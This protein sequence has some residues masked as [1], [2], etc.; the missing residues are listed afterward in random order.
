M[1]TE[2]DPGVLRNPRMDVYTG[3]EAAVSY[4]GYWDAETQY[5]QGDVVYG[6]IG[7]YP[8]LWL[9]VADSTGVEPFGSADLSE[10]RGYP[11]FGGHVTYQFDGVNFTDL[12]RVFRLTEPGTVE[13]KTE[14]SAVD[15]TFY[16]TFLNIGTNES[17]A[18]TSDGD[19]SLAPQAF[20]AGYYYINIGNANE[21][22]IEMWLELTDGAVLWDHMSWV[23]LPGTIS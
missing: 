23:Q 20:E 9:S 18:S 8:K 4:R 19:G 5:H 16:M 10:V 21:V 11:Y 22:D 2:P 6:S 13:V 3:V 17:I 1:S 12:Y 15:D 14:T 7:Q